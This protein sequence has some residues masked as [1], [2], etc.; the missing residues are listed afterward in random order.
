[1]LAERFAEVATERVDDWRTAGINVAALLESLA[2]LSV[3]DTRP[4]SRAE[5]RRLRSLTPLVVEWQPS[6]GLAAAEVGDQLKPLLRARFENEL[7]SV[8]LWPV[9]RGIT[10][11]VYW[12]AISALW[13]RLMDER[14]PKL[15]ATEGC[16]EPIG[17]RSNRLYCATHRAERQR[18]RVRE[19]RGRG[20]LLPS[21]L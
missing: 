10:A 9:K 1:M 17:S 18:Q 7:D 4:L 13:E 6:A 16:D 5:T 2:L 20:A 19:R 21:E 3:V 12:R 14:V 8:G 15:C 11:G